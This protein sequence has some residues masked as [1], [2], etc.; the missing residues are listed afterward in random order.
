MSTVSPKAFVSDFE[1]S[2]VDVLVI[3]NILT[4][5]RYFEGPVLVNAIL[6]RKRSVDGLYR[7]F[8][9]VIDEI[10]FPDRAN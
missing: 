4:L 7:P 3:P 9:E 2:G 5:Q 10:Q 1:S 8:N 6:T